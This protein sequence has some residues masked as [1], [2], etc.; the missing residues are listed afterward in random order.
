MTPVDCYK[1]CIYNVIP[2]A[3][4]KKLDKEIHSENTR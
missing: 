2:G 4:T 1:L 3:T